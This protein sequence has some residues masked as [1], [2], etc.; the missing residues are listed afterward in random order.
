[1]LMLRSARERFAIVAICAGA[2]GAGAVACT[3]VTAGAQ[4]RVMDALIAADYASGSLSALQCTASLPELPALPPMP[5]ST[6]PRPREWFFAGELG[7]AGDSHRTYGTVLLRARFVRDAWCA[8][9]LGITAAGTTSGAASGTLDLRYLLGRNSWA[10]AIELGTS[11]RTRGTHAADA[12][13]GPDA[14]ARLS[15]TTPNLWATTIGRIGEPALGAWWPRLDLR[16]RMYG[17]VDASSRFQAGGVLVANLLHKPVALLASSEHDGAAARDG[18]AA[19][20]RMPCCGDFGWLIGR[21]LRHR[22]GLIQTIEYRLEF[23]QL[24]LKA[25]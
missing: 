10:P 9:D 1:M 3:A 6:S 5:G 22:G 16:A 14:S 4:Q 18:L 25:R 15:A 11:L 8:F 13:A 20:Y 23:A 12:G 21:A 24:V 19:A 7:A 17:G 2:A